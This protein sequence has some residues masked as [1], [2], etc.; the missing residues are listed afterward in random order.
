MSKKLPGL[1][2]RAPGAP[3]AAEKDTTTPSR[4]KRG[5]AGKAAVKSQP[6]PA[7][8]AKTTKP[9]EKSAKPA[10]PVKPKEAAM[11]RASTRRKP[12]AK[13]P[14]PKDSG[15]RA[16]KAAASEG[17]REIPAE[18]LSPTTSV[19][20]AE[21]RLAQAHEIVVRRTNW[22]MAGGLVPIP[23]IDIFA[24]AG[25]QL[26]ML[27]ELSKHYDVPFRR[28]LAKS[29][30]ISLVGSILPYAAGAGLAGM[31]AKTVPVLGWGIGL[32]TTSVLAGAT[33]QA[34]GAVF[35]QHF[36]TGGTFLNFDPTATRDFFREEFQQARARTTAAASKA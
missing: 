7:A 2:R 4:T 36:E 20:N 21:H 25:V 8:G 23:I 31:F 11:A 3:D 16:T 6:A 24:V 29:I 33:T 22:A 30:V 34:T 12:G 19:E 10:T 28:N 17:S 14:M 5:A 32:A 35:I 13:G 26:G 18:V 27:D 9:R 15:P 1:N